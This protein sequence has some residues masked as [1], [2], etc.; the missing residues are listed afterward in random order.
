MTATLRARRAHGYET[1][2]PDIQAHV[3][4]TARNILE[5]GCSSGALGAALKER[6]GATVVGVELSEDYAAE[7]RERLDRVIVMDAE[8]FARGDVPEEAP[9]DC[10]IAADVLEHLVDPW[11]ALAGAAAMLEGGATVIVSVPNAANWKGLLR[12]ARTGRW[13]RDDEGV[14]DRTH[15]SWFGPEDAADLV[16]AAGVDVHAVDPRYWLTGTR[17]RVVELLSRT[18]L[19]PLFPFQVIV[20]G[21]KRSSGQPRFSPTRRGARAATRS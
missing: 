1:P 21:T 11:S 18:R 10:L 3:P 2:R 16:R 5:L 9:F 15:L 20:A 4:L 12:I 19:S 8:A 13:P 14:Y 17:L 7:A 6:Q